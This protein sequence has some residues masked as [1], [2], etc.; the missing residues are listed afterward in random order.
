MNKQELKKLK[1]GKK[2]YIVE[3]QTDCDCPF[4]DG[5]CNEPE[6][7][8]TKVWEVDTKKNVVWAKMFEEGYNVFDW[9]LDQVFTRKRDA[10]RKLK[11]LYREQGIQI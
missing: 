7:W 8:D 5:S 1:P 9:K 10:E 4:C 6:M 3:R 2:I 11:E